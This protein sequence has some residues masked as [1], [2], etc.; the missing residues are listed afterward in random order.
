MIQSIIK[1]DIKGKVFQPYRL[2]GQVCYVHL[3]KH[4]FS[5]FICDLHVNVIVFTVVHIL[6]GECPVSP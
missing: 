5:T 4:N 3:T 1:N 2:L 6:F